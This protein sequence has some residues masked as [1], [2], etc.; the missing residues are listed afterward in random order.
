MCIKFEKKNIV[1]MAYFLFFILFNL[2][3]NIKSELFDQNKCLSLGFNSNT[4]ECNLCENL[5]K[6]TDD[7]NFYNE[8]KECCQ[9]NENEQYELIILE[10]DKKLLK[11]FENI[12]NA[13][14]F[15]II[16]I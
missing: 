12:E 4:L 13:L 11:R 8:C 10:V 9:I 7:K 14:K 15:Q 2:I 3:S 16:M 1:K 6:I 5:L